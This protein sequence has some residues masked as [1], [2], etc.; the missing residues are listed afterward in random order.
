MNFTNIIIGATL[1]ISILFICKASTKE[2]YKISTDTN[3][4][5]IVKNIGEIYSYPECINNMCLTTTSKLKPG[6]KYNISNNRC[7]YNNSNL[8]DVDKIDLD[9]LVSFSAEPNVNFISCDKDI[10]TLYSYVTGRYIKIMRLDDVPI[11]L[12]HISVYN[13]NKD[14]LSLNKTIYVNPTFVDSDGTI[15]YSDPI[16]N[17]EDTLVTTFQTGITKPYIQ[18]DLGNNM[19]ISYIEIKHNSLSESTYLF[20]AYIIILDDNINDDIDE[21]GTI[22]FIKQINDFAID[23]RIYTYPLIPTTYPAGITSIMNTIET[24]KLPCT[25]C[26]NSVGNLFKNNKYL[27][28]TDNRCYKVISDNTNKSWLDSAVKDTITSN[29]LKK[30]FKSCSLTKDTTAPPEYF[31]MPFDKSI[32]EINTIGNVTIIISGTPTIQTN[33]MLNGKPTI[34]FN[35]DYGQYIDII[36]TTNFFR[37]EANEKFEIS[38]YV[39]VKEGHSVNQGAVLLGHAFNGVMFRPYSYDDGFY[40]NSQW[41]NL[42]PLIAKERWYKIFIKRNIIL[43]KLELYIDDVLKASLNLANTA[44]VNSTGQLLAI[45][46]GHSIGESFHGYISDLYFRKG[47]YVKT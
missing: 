7:V 19:D 27:H 25:G 42:K 30:Y 35:K 32:N 17:S 21:T 2:T 1:L 40:V 46:R 41:L 8:Y 34:Y 11:K 13:K 29:D 18:I 31:H 39:Y 43:Q 14:N 45:G 10:N 28:P 22:K 23:R 33:V 6:F 38:F 5:L 26:T 12:R 16:L 20:S 4:S 36:S 44:I 37:I 3:D 24:Y 9:N 47:S 15:H